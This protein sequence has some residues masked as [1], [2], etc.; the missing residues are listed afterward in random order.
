M[1]T[2]EFLESE[3]PGAVSPAA[4]AAAGLL[5]SPPR[6][7]PKFFYDALGSRLFDAM[8]ELPEYYLPRTEAAVFAA[9]AEPIRTAVRSALGEA[10]TLI[11]LGAGNSEKAERLFA[12]FSIARYVAVDIS[13]AYL[14]QSLQRLQSRWPALD[15]VGVGLDFAPALALPAQIV[16][17][18]S[19]L[20]YP[21]SSIGN[22]APAAALRFLRQAHAACAGGALLIGVDLVKPAEVLQ[23]AYDDALGLTACFNLNV[24]RHVNRLLDADFDVRDWRHVAFFEPTA[25]RIEMHLEARRAVTVRWPGAERRF[26]AGERIHT[27]DSYKWTRHGFEALLT[28]AGFRRLHTWTDP[29]QW[30]AVMLA[31]A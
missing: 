24:L 20:F 16:S 27:E 2:P 28:D 31:E 8:T 23:P 5:A 13:T 9:H 21:G 15:I 25:S 19:L 4:E 22:F 6:L 11:D 30:F 17:R 3:A 12:P 7:A 26:A 1:R 14:R 10:I 18:P 29:R